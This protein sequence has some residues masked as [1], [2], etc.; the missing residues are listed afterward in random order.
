MSKQELNLQDM[1]SIVGGVEDPVIRI[2]VNYED[3][4][5]HKYSYTVNNE[6]FDPAELIKGMTVTYTDGNGHVFTTS[7]N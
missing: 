3:G 6:R 1:N 2:T 5:G 4:N 7:R